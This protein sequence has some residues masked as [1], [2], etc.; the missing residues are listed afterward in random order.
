MRRPGE[1][2]VVYAIA[3][4][5]GR[6]LRT[7]HAGP[8]RSV[9]ALLP[10]PD[11]IR[12]TSASFEEGAEIPDRHAGEGRGPN[13]SPELSWTGVPEGARQLLLVMEDPDVPRSDPALHM[14]AVLAPGAGPLPEGALT[15]DAPGIR[16]L[17]TLPLP[18][19]LRRP[20]PG[21]HGPRALPQHGP[22]AYDFVLL[23]LD[24]EVSAAVDR[25]ADVDAIVALAQG[26]VLARGRIRG[27]QIG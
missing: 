14:V 4:V 17:T 23:A 22:H 7:R 24:A 12:L 5:L 15:P 21:Y 9:L 10:A 11:T 20:R 3:T 2:P 27:I 8:A 19:P 26:H 16:Y 25:V 1:N 18:G 13:V 6:L